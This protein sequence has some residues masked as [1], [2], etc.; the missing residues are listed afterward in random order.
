MGTSM[1]PGPTYGDQTKLAGLKREGGTFGSL[2]QKAGPGRPAQAPMVPITP[3]V[4][5]PP[6]A[7]IPP[8][9]QALIQKY[10]EASRVESRW[11]RLAQA[12]D[13]GPWVKYYYQIAQQQM[14]Q[15]AQQLKDQT[16]NFMV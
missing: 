6:E 12:A 1:T 8:E 4:T 16:P 15:A 11:G 10:A 14:F 3:Y 13:A 7:Q 5:P 2:V 9:H